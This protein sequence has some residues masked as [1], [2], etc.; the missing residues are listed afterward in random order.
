MDWTCAP[1]SP[2]FSNVPRI[3]R[4][5]LGQ[6]TIYPAVDRGGRPCLRVAECTNQREERRGGFSI[7]RG[8]VLKIHPHVRGVRMRRIGN[9]K[10][11]IRPWPSFG[12]SQNDMDAALLPLPRPVPPLFGNSSDLRTGLVI[13]RIPSALV[14]RDI[15]W[16]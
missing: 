15:S 7:T 12:M 13:S 5:A 8:R 4:T 6:D 16:L 14:G 1:E 2:S 10:H 11:L 9:A 3:Q